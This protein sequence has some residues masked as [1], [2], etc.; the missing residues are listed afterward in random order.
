MKRICRTMVVF[1]LAV[2][3]LLT[4]APIAPA[5]PAGPYYVGAFGGVVIPQDLTQDYGPD[6]ALKDSWAVGGKVGYII[7]Q[8]NYLAVELE[9]TYLAKQDFDE[10]YIDGHISSHNFMAN[11]LFRYPQGKIHPYIGGG[12]GVSDATLEVHSVDNQSINYDK[13]DTAFACQFIAGVNIEII[14]N[15]SVDLAYKYL[16]SQHQFNED[17]NGYNHHYYHTDNHVDT[18]N[19][20]V[21]AG[22]NFHF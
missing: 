20:I 5:Q 3:L 15:L 6:I 9:Y 21:Q 22:I 4:T 16:Y 17:Y 12:L 10:P 11:I 19:S 1:S 7:P 8:V 14:P 13:S 2:F 18:G